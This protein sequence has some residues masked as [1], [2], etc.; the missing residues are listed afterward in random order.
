MTNM[1][2][3]CH[4]FITSKWPFNEKEPT[5]MIQSNDHNAKN[6]D[7]QVPVFSDADMNSSLCVS[8]NWPHSLVTCQRQR[9]ELCCEDITYPRCRLGNRRSPKTESTVGHQLGQ[10]SW[11]YLEIVV[12]QTIF[13]FCCSDRL[14]WLKIRFWGLTSCCSWYEYLFMSVVLLS[15]SQTGWEL[16]P[17]HE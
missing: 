9:R 8:F 15:Q 14:Y 17:Q 12:N 1:H 13:G 5:K 4:T 10:A 16:N 3:Q 7:F 6:L 2:D 11:V